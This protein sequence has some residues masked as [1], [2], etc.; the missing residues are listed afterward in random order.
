M[1]K[2]R[3][4][5]VLRRRADTRARRRRSN[6]QRLVSLLKRDGVVLEFRIARKLDS[7]NAW[8]KHWTLGH[9]L[10]K[11][12]LHAFQTALAVNAGVHSMARFQ[13]EGHLP[14]C[15]K[16]KM[17]VTVTRQVPS[18]RNFIKDDDD[19]RYTTKPINDAL[20]H[21]GLIYDDAR[22]WLEQPM[23]VQEVSPDHLYWTLVRIEPSEAGDADSVI[24][25]FIEAAGAAR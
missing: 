24:S 20:K 23:P 11:R 13:L 12:W 5:F 7:P 21:A 1:V 2:P 18:R 17:K 19:L 10:M 14:T 25:T 15:P 3:A 22:I 8:R 9:N 16:M 4:R 6:P